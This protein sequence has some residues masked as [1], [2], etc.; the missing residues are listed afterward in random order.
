MIRGNVK[1]ILSALVGFALAAGPAV[2][3]EDDD[4]FVP[5]SS[6]PPAKRIGGASRGG[7]SGAN[8]ATV[9]IL[10]PADNVGLT[11]RE[12]PVIYW[13]LSADT[14]NPVEVA[15]NDLKAKE[16]PLLEAT[17]KGPKKAGLHKLDVAS[18]K[19]DGNAVKL[20]P[21][22]D[23]EVSISVVVPSGAASE[24][25]NASARIQCID[26][27][28]APAAAA[29]EKDRAKQAAIYGKEGLWFDYLDAL[30]AAIEAKPK[31]E[32]LIQKRAKALAAQQLTWTPDGKIDDT[33]GNRAATKTK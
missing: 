6:S 22:Q 13:Y 3:Q 4:G 12:Q 32:A 7:S 17:I 11:S 28:D 15:I 20:K 9:S 18:V 16:E 5:K 24:N 21:G 30:N 19:Q 8:A 31:D 14:D 33:S 10:A 1:F 25:P 29:K 2:A 26:P 23:Y 27:K